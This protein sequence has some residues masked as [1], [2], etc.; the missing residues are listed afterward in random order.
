MKDD[1][2]NDIINSDVRIIYLD[3][4]LRDIKLL[5]G[6]MMLG[7]FSI[8]KAVFDHVGV[9]MGV[10]YLSLIV[11]VVMIAWGIH[12]YFKIRRRQR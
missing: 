7:I 1:T 12:D 11:G 10:G 9:P 6:A 2:I 4:H 3:K 8:M 5:F